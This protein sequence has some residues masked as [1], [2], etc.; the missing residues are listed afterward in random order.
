MKVTFYPEWGKK[1]ENIFERYFLM[2]WTGT[3]QHM[4]REGEA[5]RR[6]RLLRLGL[7]GGRD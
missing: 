5:R 4:V 7:H 1:K 6:E 2:P 3:G